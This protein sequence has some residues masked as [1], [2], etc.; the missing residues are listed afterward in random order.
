MYNYLRLMLVLLLAPML[1]TGQAKDQAPC[2]D[3]TV[4]LSGLQVLED[5]DLESLTELTQ[6][7]VLESIPDLSNLADLADLAELAELQDIVIVDQTG[8]HA[9]EEAM[10]FDAEKRKT[11]DKTFKVSSA[12]GLKIDNQWGKVHVNTWDKK[13]MRV[14]VDVIARASTD[15]RAQAILNSVNIQESREGN[16]YVFRTQKEPMNI[17]GKHSKS[18]EINY[19][20]YMPAE[21]AISIKNQ[22]GDVYLASMKGKAEI[23]VKYGALKCD[24]LTNQGNTI[25]LT[26]GSGDCNYIKG[27]NISVAYGNMKV[28]EASGLQGSSKF[29]DFSIGN[30]QEAIDMKVQ[31]GSF[32][33]DNISNNVRKISLNSGFSPLSLRFADDSAFNF[34]VNVQFGNFNVDKS[35]ITITSLEKDYTSAEYKGKYGNTASK[36]E[37][38]IISK[39]GDVR[40][41]K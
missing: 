4:N 23:D 7:A 9:A 28:G 24:R 39:Y 15:D 25:K 37:V 20:I 33:V 27:G 29:S 35:L 34:D 36:A 2:S 5:L 32:N 22:F 11:I 30:L 6:L 41:I 38:S 31:Y 3:V 26:Y 10:A 17:S 8:N 1:A 40:F 19:T 13:E 14:K 18:L 16:A 21:N 12:D